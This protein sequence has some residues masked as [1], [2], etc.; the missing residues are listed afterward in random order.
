MATDK[1]VDFD[2]VTDFISREAAIE[3]LSE[4]YHHK[5]EIQHIALREALNRVP[6]ADVVEVVRCKDC[7]HWTGI[8]CGYCEVWEHYISNQDYFCGSGERR[9]DD[10]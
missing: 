4:F 6:T 1:L 5:S 9:A 3:T 8:N 10:G 2:H 7:K